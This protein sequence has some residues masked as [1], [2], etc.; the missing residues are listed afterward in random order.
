MLLRLFHFFSLPPSCFLPGLKVDVEKLE[1]N[2]PCCKA[3]DALRFHHPW[4]GGGGARGSDAGGILGLP[5]FLSLVLSTWGATYE[6][7]THLHSTLEHTQKQ[8]WEHGANSSGTEA[9]KS[10][11]FIVEISTFSLFTANSSSFSRLAGRQDDQ[12]FFR[13]PSPQEEDGEDGVWILGSVFFY[14]GDGAFGRT[15]G[16]LLY[17]TKF[18]IGT[19]KISFC[20]VWCLDRRQ[21]HGVVNISYPKCCTNSRHVS[22][23]TYAVSAGGGS[24]HCLSLAMAGCMLGRW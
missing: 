10:R 2:I 17:N 11:G 8:L 3:S 5:F 7:H 15:P 13:I 22:S 20:S 21:F 18:C 4:G 24:T 23:L 12:C 6:E 1:Q 16:G 9:T 19:G 14:I